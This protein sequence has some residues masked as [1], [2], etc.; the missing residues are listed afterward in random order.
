MSRLGPN[1][2]IL[3]VPCYLSRPNV[4][5]DKNLDEIVIIFC[6]T[7]TAAFSFATTSRRNVE[8]IDKTDAELPKLHHFAFEFQILP[9]YV[10]FCENINVRELLVVVN[11]II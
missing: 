2:S 3:Y 9:S 4:T 1:I 6:A 11:V 10:L 5:A 8:I 7:F